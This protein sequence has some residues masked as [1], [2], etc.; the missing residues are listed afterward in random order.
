VRVALPG[1][2]DAERIREGFEVYAELFE[3]VL[4]REGMSPLNF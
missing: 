1:R 4:G 2:R 3:R